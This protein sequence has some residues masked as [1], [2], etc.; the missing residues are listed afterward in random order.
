MTVPRG[1]GSSRLAIFIRCSDQK[2]QAPVSRGPI[3]YG[4]RFTSDRAA[5]SIYIATTDTDVKRRWI[6]SAGRQCV[7]ALDVR[8]CPVRLRPVSRAPLGDTQRD[9]FG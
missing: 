5:I 1:L 3:S 6:I 4:A 7:G 8:H 2:N 9:R